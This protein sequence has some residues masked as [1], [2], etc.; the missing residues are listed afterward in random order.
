M[1]RLPAVRAR[2]TISELPMSDFSSTL[3]PLASSACLYSSPRMNCSVK[4]FVPI[5]IVGASDGAPPPFFDESELPP[6]PASATIRTAIAA[7]RKRDLISGYGCLVTG[8]GRLRRGGG[9]GE[10][11]VERAA[12][13]GV[14]LG[15]DAGAVVLPDA[16]ADGPPAGRA[17]V[18]AAPVQAVERLEDLL[19]V[20][21]VHADAVVA[22]GEAHQPVAALG[23]HG[24]AR[25]LLG[26]LDR[27]ADEV[28]EHLA[29]VC[30]VAGHTGQLVHV[31]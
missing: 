6:Q 14:A 13:A 30:R 19:R 1:S 2:S 24:D 7:V 8:C 23:A 27:V 20:L 9:G 31:D 12:L 3:K 16:L 18:V 22:D 5:V 4:F 15:P 11:E 17:R 26:E 10:L 21:R 29:K 28:L 25:L